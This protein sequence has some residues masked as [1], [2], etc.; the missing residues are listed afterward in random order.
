M[1]REIVFDKKVNIFS[2]RETT[3]KCKRLK[4]EREMTGGG[5]NKGEGL[6]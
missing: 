1:S 5:G 4:K 2:R 6:N 3:K